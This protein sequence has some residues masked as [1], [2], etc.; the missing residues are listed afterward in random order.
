MLPRALLLAAIA[1]FSLVLASTLSPTAQSP[2]SGA[3]EGTSPP[4]I[5]AAARAA[6]ASEEWWQTASADL[7]RAE[8]A[9][10]A[11]ST[12]LQAPNRAHGFR[13]YFHPDGIE[14][15]PRTGDAA[16]RWRWRFTACRF[17]RAGA[18]TDL[19]AATPTADGARVSYARRGLIEWYENKEEGVEQGFT[20]RERPGSAGALRIEGEIG[21]DLRAELRAGEAAVDLLDAVGA[22]VLRYGGL[23]VEDATGREL[24]ARLELAGTELAI[25][26]E[27]GGA[28]YPLTVDPLMTSPDWI[29]ESNQ[30]GA[31]F[32]HSAATAGDVN[33]DGYDDVI[34]GACEYDNGETDEGRA[35][36]YHGTAAGLA[37]DPAWT[38]ESNQAGADFGESVAMAGDVNGDGYD[39]VIVGAYAYD[40]GKT[41]EGRGYVYHGSA[42]GLAAAPAWTATGDNHSFGRC[43]AT[44]GDVNGDGY[45]DVIVGGGYSTG[46]SRAYVYHGSVAGLAATPAWTAED[47]EYDFGRSVATAGDVNRD[48][49][50]DVIVGAWDH[51]YVYH[52]SPQGLAATPAWIAEADPPYPSP[53]FGYSVAAAGDVNGDG[54]SDVIVGAPEQGFRGAAHVYHGSAAGLAAAP[55]WIAWSN[56]DYAHFGNCVAT[57]GDVNGDGYSDVIVGANRYDNGETGEGRAYV[58]H[59]SA[60]G[61]AT[62]PAWTA[63]SNQA[64][65]DF[66]ISVATAG[67]VNGDGYSDVI[68]GAVYYSNGESGE[69]RAYVYL[70]AVFGETAATLPGVDFCAAAWGDYDNDGDLDILLTG[71]TATERMSR[72]YRNDGGGVFSDIGAGLPDVSQGAVAWGDY[73]NDGDLDILLTG[74]TGTGQIVMSRVYRNDGGGVFSDIAAGLPGVYDGAAA[75]GDCDND[76]DLDI[77]LTGWAGIAGLARVYRNDGG[78][79]FSNAAA[80]LPGV[81]GSAAA[82]G[83]Y[84]NDGDLDILLTGW[85]GTERITRLYRND[86]SGVFSDIAAGLQGV[87]GSAAAWGDYDNDGDLDIVLTGW[88]GI[89]GIARL[90]RNDGGGVF[91]SVAAGLRRVYDGS[92]G[93]GD[94]DNDG[95]LDILLTGWTGT[96]RTACVYRNDGGGGFSG[97]TSGLEGVRYSAAVWGDYDNDEDLDVLLAGDTSAGNITRLYRNDAASPNTPPTAPGGLT[98]AI[99]NDQLTLGWNAAAD[100]QTPAAGLS[101]NLRIGTTPGGNEVMAAMARALAGYR[102]VVAL[103]NAQ[104][105]RSWTV[106]VTPGGRYY[107]SVQA[108]DAAFA[109]SLFAAEQVVQPAGVLAETTP[110]P[111]RFALHTNMPNP[112]NPTT[113]IGYDVAVS[114]RVRLA[115]YDPAGRV[116]RVLVAAMREPGAYEAVWDGR[117]EGGAQAASGVYLCRMEAASFSATRQMTLL[118]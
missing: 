16:P 39:D 69:G 66:G 105:R 46:P 74:W 42:T 38:A 80:G 47:A 52:G 84:D 85:T 55:A 26:V 82:W 113:V 92:A 7:A 111:A 45:S 90:Y 94:Y 116:V 118:K 30:A 89:V 15:V 78:G 6:G 25:V 67:D 88:T 114:G 104:E 101:Y 64:V 27:D 76:G 77:L 115:I 117:T 91:T 71:T 37:T 81:S 23:R 18:L 22:V 70:G 31:G 33:G 28:E 65:A 103:G 13:T 59:G 93:W 50:W 1:V 83:D 5:A 8:Y 48:G 62:A 106:R 29:A 36:V 14:I 10:S 60:T 32:G 19:A 21:G 4:V 11:S 54:Y 41:D 35:Y 57:A 98:A 61:L 9:V 102:R 3:E 43:V 63:E 34:V 2:S 79:V 49:F 99:N 107:W 24:P 72:V 44:A 12:G 100:A 95:D 75:W 110:L 58:Y 109:G 68:V 96:E 53:A 51:A 40:N 108:I 73:D 17:G 112:F 87:S 86:G 56:Q 20:V 97:V